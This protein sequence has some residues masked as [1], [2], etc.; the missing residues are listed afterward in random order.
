[1]RTAQERPGVILLNDH[2]GHCAQLQALAGRLQRD[3]RVIALS[4]V[5]HGRTLRE[6][7]ARVLACADA[8]FGRGEPFH[9]VG[10]GY[11]GAVAL[12]LARK[13]PARIAGLALYEPHGFGVPRAQVNVPALLM[14]GTES[15]PLAHRAIEA[16]K[17]ALPRSDMALVCGDH[18]APV[19]DPEMIVPLL[20]SFLRWAWPAALQLAKT[21]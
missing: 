20:R 10:Y 4:L 16:L 21:A 7:T 8:M 3:F 14:V 11:G 15:P 5:G 17:S 9:L 13:H 2:P 1:M 6:K 18:S 19:T 12:R